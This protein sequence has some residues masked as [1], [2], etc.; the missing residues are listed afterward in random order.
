[1]KRLDTS[2]SAAC[3]G[4]HLAR[5][6]LAL[7]ALNG[8]VA[9][10]AD[11]TPRE[12]GFTQSARDLA[13]VPDAPFYSSVSEFLGTWVGTIAEP[14]ALTADEETPIY[15]FPS[16]STRIAIEIVTGDDGQPSGHVTFGAGEPPAPPEDPDVGYPA[17]VSYDLLT[18]YENGRY[19][20]SNEFATYLPTTLG[21]PPFEGFAYDLDIGGGLSSDLE[22]NTTAPDG[23][24]SLLLSSNQPLDPWC[25][26][27]TS[28]R[29]PLSSNY[30]CMPYTG[31][32]FDSVADGTGKMCTLYGPADTSICLPDFSNLGECYIEGEPVAQM[33]CDQLAI[34]F[35]GYCLCDETGCEAAPTNE[36][37]TLRQSGDELVGLFQ[38]LQFKNA[39]GLNIPLGELRLQRER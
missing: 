26:L 22:G 32:S 3:P 27:Q 38:N 12:L 21:L 1:M 20:D 23:V 24:L 11:P 14:L 17:N 4:S 35:R 25:K 36:R 19:G 10:C 37:L 6:L 8:L 7:S 30:A 33:N 13:S 39:R 9:A 18:G 5:T 2:T 34:C 28:Y 29:E 15:H 31:G 16:G